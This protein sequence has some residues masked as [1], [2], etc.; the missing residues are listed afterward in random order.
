[1]SPVAGYQAVGVRDNRALQHPVV[2]MASLD[3]FRQPRR[4]NDCGGIFQD[5]DGLG[6]AFLIRAEFPRQHPGHLLQDEEG[7]VKLEP[8]PQGQF[9]DQPLVAGKV[10]GGDDHVGV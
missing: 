6:R 8:S 9:Q 4:S 1:M 5:P 3:H 7:Q 2:S 10:Q